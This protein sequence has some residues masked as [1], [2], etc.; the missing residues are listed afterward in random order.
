MEAAGGMERNEGGLGGDKVGEGS[1]EEVEFE[2]QKT[3]R[4][5]VDQKILFQATQSIRPVG[6]RQRRRKTSKFSTLGKQV[7]KI[8]SAE[9]VLNPSRRRAL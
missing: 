7:S 8:Y 4:I 2:Q 6:Q 5:M 3:V 9:P 1:V